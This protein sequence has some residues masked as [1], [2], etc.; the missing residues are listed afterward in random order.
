[1]T[2]YEEICKISDTL[3]HNRV[4]QMGM[5]EDLEGE[6]MR[7]FDRVV[8]RYFND[9]DKFADEA[10]CQQDGEEGCDDWYTNSYGD[11][12]NTVRG[13]VLFLAEHAPCKAVRDAAME[14]VNDG[15]AYRDENYERLLLGLARAMEGMDWQKATHNEIDSRNYK[16]N[17]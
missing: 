7:A 9:G 12:Y 16:D 2:I 5:C 4:P 14:I 3:P 15:M 17:Q 11:G 8:Y 1:M 13:S 10:P 6:T